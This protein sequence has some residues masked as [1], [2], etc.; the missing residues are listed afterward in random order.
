MKLRHRIREIAT[1]YVGEFWC[2]R[3]HGPL[4]A[5]LGGYGGTDHLGRRRAE[6]FGL[7]CVKCG[8]SWEK[9]GRPKLLTKK[10]EKAIAAAFGNAWADHGPE[11]L[12]SH[13]VAR[14]AL[15]PS[16]VE[17]LVAIQK[18][19]PTFAGDLI[20]KATEKNLRELGLV[21]RLEGWATVTLEGKRWLMQAGLE[22]WDE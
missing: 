5:S 2:R 13:E 7:R 19:G 20:S 10:Q 8:R 18:H 3:F 12:T 17:Q 11:K 21:A 22:R 4:F 15:I 9:S 1:F 14:V 16:E 6:Y